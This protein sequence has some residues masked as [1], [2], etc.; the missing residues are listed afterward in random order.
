MQEQPIVTLG[1]G[2]AGAIK[3]WM[4][5]NNAPRRGSDRDQVYRML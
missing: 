5:G 2:T 3:T 4:S 1:P